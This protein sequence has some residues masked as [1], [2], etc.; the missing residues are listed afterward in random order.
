M[1][2]ISHFFSIDFFK[3]MKIIKLISMYKIN[4]TKKGRNK[5]GYR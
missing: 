5:V 3:K 4:E 1:A 2:Q